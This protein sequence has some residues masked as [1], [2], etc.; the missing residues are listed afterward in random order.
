MTARFKLTSIQ[1][2]YGP[3]VALELDE[4]T[5]WPGRL[6]TLTGPNGSGK[7]TLLN[8]LALLTKPERGEVVFAGQRITWNKAELTLL[9]KRITLLHQSP[10]L[11]AGA[12]FGNVA[13]GLKVR[14]M[15]AADLRRSVSAALG[16]VGLDGFEQRN[17]RQL[18]G[19]EVRR[20]AL[21][22]ALVLKPDILL[23]DEPLANLDEES[24][25]VL[26][27]LIVSLPAQGTTVV[28]ATHDLE[29]AERMKS[30]EIRL[31][32]G[33]VQPALGNQ[34]EPAAS[35]REGVEICQA[36]K[37]RVELSSAMSFRWGLS[38]WRFLSR[39]G[40]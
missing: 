26:E 30:N 7:S 8:I 24:A 18:S 15:A 11:F 10:Y 36:L 5:L 40:G 20:V 29:Q 13:F 23:L 32:D 9:R 38:A 17:V 21:A 34:P 22:R 6:Y 37:K 25:K 35:C 33:R 14:R 1:K 39:W 19:G 27:S 3:K 31:L 12:V 16:T 4:L 2:R 28:M